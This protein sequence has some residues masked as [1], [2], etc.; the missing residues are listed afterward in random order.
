MAGPRVNTSQYAESDM[1]SHI[2]RKV[3]ALSASTCRLS[4]RSRTLSIAPIT[5]R[6]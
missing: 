4:D 1:A 5:R 6:E 2:N 3:R